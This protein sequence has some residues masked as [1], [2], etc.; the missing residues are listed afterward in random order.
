MKR[1][2]QII[3]AIILAL[4]LVVDTFVYLYLNRFFAIQSPVFPAL[5]WA[6]T[7]YMIARLLFLT[8]FQSF[9]ERDARVQKKYFNYF[10]VFVL[11]YI[12]KLVLMA[13]ALAERIL[14]GIVEL[15]SSYA[16]YFDWL[17]WLGTGLSVLLFVLILYGIVFGRFH[18]KRE[19]HDLYHPRLPESFEGF[20]IVH[21]SD[22]HIGSW[23]GHSR[24]LQRAVDLINKENPDLILFTGDLFNNFYEEAEEFKETLMQMR[25]KEGKYAVLGNHDYGD[26]FHWDSDDIYRSN[27]ENIK[28]TYRQLGFHLLCNA[29]DTIE[30]SGH[31]LGI[32][33]VEN[34]GLP[35]FHQYGDLRQALSN[36]N[37]SLFNVLLSHDPSHW[38]EEVVRNGQ[39]QLTL[40]GHTHGMQFGIYTPWLRWSPSKVKYREWGGWYSEDE[41]FLYVNKGLGYIGFPGRIGMRPEITVIT[42]KQKKGTA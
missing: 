5:F 36:L 28:E 23:T 18:F 12:P 26:Y 34:W 27:F 33:G 20:R 15:I 31:S 35:P 40:S 3:W 11:F 39:V 37:G 14:S 7:L 24:Q 22:L 8:R 41:R 2:F 19:R 38:R 4:I 21:I 1:R 13:L 6:V 25:A 10:G 42:L 29:S 17:T 32:A 30:R 9:Y 16:I